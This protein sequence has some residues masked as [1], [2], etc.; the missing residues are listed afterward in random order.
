MSIWQQ[1]PRSKGDMRYYT[2][3][4]DTSSSHDWS[5]FVTTPPQRLCSAQTSI[6]SQ[7]V[8]GRVLAVASGGS[9]VAVRLVRV[10]VGVLVVLLHQRR[11]VPAVLWARG[12]AVA[13]LPGPLV[14]IVLVRGHQIAALDGGMVGS[15]VVA[16]SILL[17]LFEREILW[18]CSLYV[19]IKI[20]KSHFPHCLTLTQT[21]LVPFQ[22]SQ[23]EKEDRYL[24]KMME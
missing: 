1:Q 20:Y 14:V 7:P 4:R 13:V 17:G 18:M 6:G 23:W 19:C 22:V 15:R 2:D 8:P 9:A 11:V 10:L 5:R 16:V 21:K 12:Q 24:R 3:I